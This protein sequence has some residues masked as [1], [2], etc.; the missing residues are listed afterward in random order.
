MFITDGPMS[1]VHYNGTAL[2]VSTMS[3]AVS[4]EVA[5]GSPTHLLSCIGAGLPMPQTNWYR[6]EEGVAERRIAWGSTFRYTDSGNIV[7]VAD[8]GVNSSKTHVNF[9]VTRTS[10][11]RTKLRD[12]QLCFIQYILY[13]FI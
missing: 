8:N 6:V 5:E 1:S 2:L 11:I 12:R 4:L 13:L 3:G 10:E 7:C 9:T